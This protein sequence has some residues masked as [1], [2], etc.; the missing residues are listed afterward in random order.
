VNWMT[1][2]QMRTRTLNA[3]IL[4]GTMKILAERWKLE[5]SGSISGQSLSKSFTSFGWVVLVKGYQTAYPPTG[6]KM[7]V[8]SRFV[9]FDHLHVEVDNELR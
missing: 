7:R 5:D 8:R 9:G 1:T 3:M 4:D 6:S 2:M